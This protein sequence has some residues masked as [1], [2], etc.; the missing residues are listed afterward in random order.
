MDALH[1]GWGA[2]RVIND[3]LV[4]PGQGFPTHGHRNMEIIT[5]VLDGAL[6]HKDSM[7]NGSV[8]KPGDV[9]YMSAGEGVRHSEFNALRDKSTRLLQIWILP[10]EHGGSPRYNQKTFFEDKRLNKLCLLVS[11]DGREDSIDIRQEANIWAS[12]LDSGKA[13]DFK[14]QNE[15]RHVWI[16]NI[17]G[18]LKI[19]DITL[20][21]GDALGLTGEKLAT[22]KLEARGPS[23]AHFLIFD[24]P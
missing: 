8:I 4:A 6:E 3:D 10:R 19:A 12:I 18:Q 22:L 23:R 5:Y 20:E 15:E 1:M 2:L 17:E 9:Q 11:A 7:G 13:L 16:H 21:A 14:I 24:T